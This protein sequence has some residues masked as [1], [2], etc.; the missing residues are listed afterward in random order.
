MKKAIVFISAIF[1]GIT[2]HAQEGILERTIPATDIKTMTGEVF[3]TSNIDNAGKPMIISFF[4]LWCK[5]CLR[6][7]TA[8]NDVYQDWQEE[9]G[10]KL[11]AISIDD[12]RSMPNVMPTVNGNGWEYE[13]YCDPNGDFKRAMGVNMIPHVFILDGEKKVVYQ[14]TSYAEGGENELYEIV[15]K[16]A[17]GESIK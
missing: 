2:L 11:V 8:I 16:L 10:V 4:A 13:F 3:N 14:H 5:P 15:K 9:T 12:A 17:A 7:L 1:L 6:E